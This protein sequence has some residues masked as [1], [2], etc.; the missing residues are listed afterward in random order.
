[1]IGPNIPLLVL[2]F[3]LDVVDGVRGLDLEGDGLSGE[4]LDEDLHPCCGAQRR[5]TLRCVG[6]VG[7]G[8]WYCTVK[9][10]EAAV[11][12]W[13]ELQGESLSAKSTR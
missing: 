3:G 9:P 2:D 11:P 4:C 1:M 12:H 6:G 8:M 5:A 10:G 7:R 13:G